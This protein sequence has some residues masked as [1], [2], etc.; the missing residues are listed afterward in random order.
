MSKNHISVSDQIVPLK[1]F[2]KSLHSRIRINSKNLNLQSKF[3][4]NQ[5][6]PY[7]DYDKALL[8]VLEN[9]YRKYKKPKYY[10][11]YEED[12]SGLKLDSGSSFILLIL[13]RKHY[14]DVA[15]DV[16]LARYKEV[17]YEMISKLSNCHEAH[18]GLAKL[19]TYEG[20]YEQAEQHLNI[21]LS[22]D[23][24]SEI[25][26]MWLGVLKSLSLNSKAKALASRRFCESNIYL[27]LARKNLRKVE[28]LWS[29]MNISLL[30]YLIIGQEIESPQ[31]YASR[32]KE[33][34]N[35]Y[36][37]LAWSEVLMRS[38]TSANKDRSEAVLQELIQVYPS[39]PESYIKLWYH[40]YASKSYSLSLSVAE[41][42]FLKL[43][44]SAGEYTVII[45]LN[46]ARS[47]FKMEKFRS[48]FELL[49][50]MYTQYSQYSV[51]LYH[52]G[53]LCLKSKDAV[54]LGSAVGALEE[55]IKICS[56]Y[57]HGGI[58]YWLM[59]GYILGNDKVQAYSYAKTGIQ[60]L[61]GLADKFSGGSFVEKSYE[62]KVIAKMNEMK[63][64]VKDMHIDILNMEMLEKIIDNFQPSKLEEAKIHC[65]NIAKFDQAE[66]AICNAKLMLAL[67]EREQAVQL[68]R[69]TMAISSLQMKPFFMLA[70]IL[71]AGP[72]LHATETLCKEM[73]KR[74]RNSMIPVQVWIKAHMIY[75]KC[76][77]GRGEYQQ[78]ILIL[79]SLAQVQPT[80]FIPDLEY[81]RQLQFATSKQQLLHIADNLTVDTQGQCDI[82]STI[83]SRA[84]LLTS[85]RNLSSMIIDSECDREIDRNIEDINGE[86]EEFG[87]RTPEPLPKARISKTPVGD[88]ANTGFSVSISY[89][90][91]YMIGKISAKYEVEI[92]D[93]YHAMHDFLNIHHYWMREGIERDEKVKVKGQFWLAVLYYLKKDYESAVNIFKNIM[94]MLFQ[95]N[96]EKMSSKIQVYLKEHEQRSN[97]LSI[98][99]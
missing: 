66:G 59:V 76:L 42:A 72:D 99:H 46:Y 8:R 3:N 70:E 25:Y 26:N 94:S 95:L 96:L 9:S 48:C 82:Q 29:L 56:E 44:E 71:N 51:Y 40:Y 91:L 12:K 90:F 83:I 53:R 13:R 28:L 24:T 89:K 38:E 1:E 39:R 7:E 67:G 17:C 97:A 10:S 85:R 18:F 78:C 27:A 41:A 81:T 11:A 98:Y 37:Y 87:S 34:D 19:L 31:H 68:L 15:P 14:R 79:K 69:K 55:C 92:E 22:E 77:L 20:N 47:L 63:D 5:E 50:M 88:A 75:I 65:R 73:M 6:I 64:I 16:E 23:K 43:A 54:F 30:D 61:T 45:N 62:K 74:C 2:F 58:Y 93:G 21:A 57:R 33:I 32:I 4:I 49:Q 52:Y 36:G 84:K 86:V 60:I 80:P 35:F